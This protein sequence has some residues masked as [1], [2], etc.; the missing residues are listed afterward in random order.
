VCVRCKRDCSGVARVKNPQGQY[1][2]RECYDT[3]ALGLKGRPGRGVA[4]A[5]QPHAGEAARFAAPGVVVQSEAAEDNSIPLEEIVNSGE[6]LGAGASRANG[7]GPRDM[8]MCSYCGMPLKDG[9]IIC[10]GCGMNSTTG[11][12]LNGKPASAAHNCVKC[13]YDMRGLKTPRCP[14]CGT[15]NTRAVRLKHVPREQELRDNYLRPAV[16]AALGLAVSI[17]L[18]GLRFGWTQVPS[19]LLGL[20]AGIVAGVIGFCICGLIWLGFET[21][22]AAIAAR[23][24]GI[25]CLTDAASELGALVPF[26]GLGYILPIVAYVALLSDMFDLDTS[27]AA[28]VSLVTLGVYVGMWLLLIRYL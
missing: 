13:G 18:A 19:H 26:S 3:E 5:E 8:P 14:E 10:L 27:D 9:A 11:L 12:F 2:C 20:A 25:V 6:G 22:P 4:G 15:V 17:P 7:R 24:A 16:Y 23:I 21:R 28:L 1:M